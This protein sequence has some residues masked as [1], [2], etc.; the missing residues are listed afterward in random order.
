MPSASKGRMTLASRSGTGSIVSL[1]RRPFGLPLLPTP[2]I[3]RESLLR[4]FIEASDA[5][6]ACL[7]LAAAGFGKSTLMTQLASRFVEMGRTVGWLSLRSEHGDPE[8]LR[9]ALHGAFGIQPDAGASTLVT[10]VEFIE[11]QR[12][13]LFVDQV[14]LLAATPAL[15]VMAE[16]VESI[17][18]ARVFIAGRNAGELKLS[19]LLLAGRLQAV[20]SRALTFSPEELTALAPEMSEPQLAQLMAHSE[21]WPVAAC[22]MALNPGESARAGEA[23]LPRMMSLYIEENLVAGVDPR[24]VRSLMD[25]AVFE[26]F[27]IALLSA[28][29]GAVNS[30]EDLASLLMNNVPFEHE[31]HVDW[32]RLYP[33]YRSYMRQRLRR[34]DASR[35]QVLHR[36]AAQWFEQHGE[37]REALRHAGYC[38][39]PAVTA[40]VMERAG[41]IRLSFHEGLSVLRMEQL[42]SLSVANAYPLLT[43]GQIYLKAQDG[44]V[45]EARTHFER[46]RQETNSFATLLGGDRAREVHNF[47]ELV[48]VVIGFYEDRPIDA[49]LTDRLERHLT[50]VVDND[51]SMV[52]A[53]ASLLCPAYLATGR[54]ED[55][56]NMADI[57]L[58]S[59]RGTHADHVVFYLEVQQTNAALA[60]GRLKEASLHADRADALAERAFGPRSRGEGIANVLKGV[61]RYEGNELDSA[62]RL[63]SGALRRDVLVNGW[64]ELY[65]E[66]FTAAA[67]TAAILHEAVEV[68]TILAEADTVA[69]QR[70]LPR[71][72][73]TVAILRLSLAT[74]AGNLPYAAN[75]MHGDTISRLIANVGVPVS[76]WNLKLRTQALLAAARLRNRLGCARDAASHLAAVDRRYVRLGDARLRFAYQALAMEVA[77]QLRRYEEA[78]TYFSE[79]LNLGLESGLVRR[80][81]SCRIPILEVFDWMMATG[82][83]VSARV[84]T[85]CT[86]ALRSATDG[87]SRVQMHKRL[88]PRRGA[89][90][91]STSDLTAR[92]SEI[93]AMIAEGL[94]SKEIAHRISI[95]ISTVKTH[96][97]NL[98]EKLGVKRRSQA[99]ARAREKL[100]I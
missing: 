28:L 74:A 10:F 95:T 32:Y 64:F 45:E 33:P 19:R 23:E 29:P 66:G 68:D 87:D 38:A 18:R 80:L 89:A 51:A 93:L 20:G 7:L 1:G 97:K 27:S 17:R 78:A 43:L 34:L 69:A 6:P 42:P 35:W 71:L 67:E 92:E 3:W 9:L 50:E 53:V 65:A 72:A 39:D 55:A 41:A 91:R 15:E 54:I 13:F 22:A 2:N 60:L 100:L 57:G 21:G 24:H 11:T 37:P 47:L 63:L 62:E 5:P 86:S 26:R 88:I 8:R 82:R 96:R 79:A 56:C 99:I 52:G 40:D 98:F 36:F 70:R 94:S 31:A 44:R 48:E 83:P 16:L 77:F 81:L 58:A 4:R 90:P 59:V 85:F 30:C 73:D 12:A 84:V 46:L 14:E 25:A 49:A 61:V 76:N 75:L